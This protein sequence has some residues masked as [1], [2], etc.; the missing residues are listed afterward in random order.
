MRSRQTKRSVVMLGATGA[1]GS[2]VVKSII[3]LNLASKITL[4]GRRE[5]KNLNTDYIEQYTADIFDPQ[6]YDKYIRDHDTAICTLGVGQPSQVSKEDFIRIDKSA[7]LDF[8]KLC[9]KNGVEHFEL[10]SSV[11]INHNSSNLYLRTKGELAEELK[12][13]HFKRLSIFQPS[14]IITP[15]NRYGL[16]QAI[17]LGLWPIIDKLFIAS[18]KKYKGI[19]VEKLGKAIAIN[20]TRPHKGVEMLVW[21][22]FQEIVE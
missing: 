21:Q 7:V 22:D 15:Q 4:L 5:I 14:M 12:A 13:L 3:E 20:L 9:K 1:V 2:Q 16:S 8:A 18:L 19:K 6:S 17:I 11:G 10:L